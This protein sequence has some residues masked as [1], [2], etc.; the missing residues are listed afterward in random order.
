MRKNFLSVTVLSLVASVMISCGTSA[1]TV[2]E[3]IVAKTDRVFD[4]MNQATDAADNEDY[5]TALATLDTLIPYVEESKEIISKMENKPGEQFIQA[6]VAFLDL[7]PEGIADYKKAIGIYQIAENN[8]QLKESY[9][10]AN[11]FINKVNAKYTELG[12]IQVE[13]AD[14][15]GLTLR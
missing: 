3:T 15:N 5:E 12:K 8:A 6:A 4:L 2:N 1:T 7:F 14:A 13:F 9:D 11:N 10:L